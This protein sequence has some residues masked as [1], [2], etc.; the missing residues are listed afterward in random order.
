M[1]KR[2]W[3]AARWV[4]ALAGAALCIHLILATGWPAI[5][6][7]LQ[8]HWIFLL[9]MTAVYTAYHVLR[10]WT[11]QICIPHTARFRDLF[12]IRLA[13]EAVAYIAVGSVLGDALK[14]ALGRGRIPVVES[15]T[16]VFA[17]KL[18]YHLSGAAFIIGGLLV[19]VFRFGVNPALVFAI[20]M[21]SV[22]FL[23]VVILM[24]SGAQPLARLLRHVR[25]RRP[26]LREAILKTEQSLFQFNREHPRE[27]LAVF[28]LDLLSYFYSV[29]EV[30][31]IL[32]CL[33]L[34]P[35]AIDLW[36]YQ[37]VVKVMS[38]G[39]IVV[40]AN[41]GI[42]EATNVYLS[43]QLAFGQEAGMITALFVRIRATA[44]SVIGYLWFLW[45]LRDS[46]GEKAALQ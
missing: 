14:V 9:A 28:A 3:S 2:L 45:L 35:S 26:R 7:A 12:G 13:G 10:T 4:I 21:L 36:Y 11:L 40:P 23:A 44:W 39:M 33:G 30:Y 37:S 22:L 42:F 25:V 18:I 32:R 29:G 5:A 17:E 19:A 38:T 43:R 46:P 31:V 1:H 15:A 24:S 41:L 20:A 8:N 6:G 27:F 16:G 34:H